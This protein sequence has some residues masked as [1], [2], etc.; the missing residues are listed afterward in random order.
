MSVRHSQS[1]DVHTGSLLLFLSLAA[2]SLPLHTLTFNTNTGAL[3]SGMP[4]PLLPLLTLLPGFGLPLLLGVVLGGLELR[5][6]SMLD[7][8]PGK[9]GR[10]IFVAVMVLGTYDAGS[11]RPERYGVS[12]WSQMAPNCEVKFL[13]NVLERLCCHNLRF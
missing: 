1:I 6:P 10:T 11:D 8:R 2:R 5:P 7:K 13:Q 12:E 3:V 9:P 4:F